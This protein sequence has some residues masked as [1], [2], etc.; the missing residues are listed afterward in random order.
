MKGSWARARAALA[1]HDFRF[2]LASRLV[3]QFADG[4]FQAYLVDR[5]VFLDP[6]KHSTALGVTE[7]FAVLIIPFSVLGP[8]AG[9]FIDRWSRRRILLVT[10][11]VRAAS[12]LVLVPFAGHD[13]VL[14][15]LALAVVSLNRFW[16]ST[17]GAAMPAL[18]PDEDLLVGNSM[19]VTVGTTITF[20]GLVAGTQL[21]GPLGTRGLL[22]ATAVCWPVGALLVARI[23]SPLRAARPDAAIREDV[24]RALH[25]L[26]AGFRRLVATPP[27][28]G[29]VTSVTV[30]QILVGIVVVLSVVVFK[31]QFRQGVASYGRIVG[32]GG[33]GVL[34]GALTVG[35]LENRLAKPRIAATA[36]A[37]AGVACL[38]GA[39][40]VAA[41][42]ML[43]VSFVIGLTYPWRKVPADTIVQET[44][45]DRYRGRVFSLYDI[46]FAMSR[47]L[48]GLATL[49]LLQILSARAIVALVGVVY[50][51]WTPVLPWWVRRPMRVR[52]RF[53][54]GGRAEE[55]PRF[56]VIAGDEEP[57]E[58][59]RSATVEQGG[60]RSRR[61][62]VRTEDGARMEL[63]GEEGSD[64]WRV[65]RV[66]P[67]PGEQAERPAL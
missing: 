41:L 4:L 35:S 12:A 27:A 45:P 55:T 29:S 54:E 48:A 30:D 26:S 49:A 51:A 25:D 15:P 50:L 63:V 5:L 64:R 34:V 20:A 10:P 2:L 18:V 39:I 61:F 40:R 47:V 6:D 3:S 60:A 57:V 19:N 38:A 17:A 65:E 62:L 16:L 56:V 7:A 58:V 43:M 53:Y 8:L 52:V 44:I 9:V 22:V 42:G 23:R 14:Y 66:E 36:F 33:V 46:A 1:S 67:A 37:L 21:A 11:V 31:E 24:R 13:A 28:M 32:A 59:V